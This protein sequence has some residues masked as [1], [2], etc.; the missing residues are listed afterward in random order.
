[1]SLLMDAL[2]KAEAAK[3]QSGQRQPDAPV[4]LTLVAA[5][6]SP[7]PPSDPAQI[8]ASL[9]VER[10]AI[11]A[12]E[13]ARTFQHVPQA[14]ERDAAR[15]FFAARQPLKLRS[16]PRLFLALAASAAMALVTH[17]WWQRPSAPVGLQ[18]RPGPSAAPP[19][20]PAAAHET[21][22]SGATLAVAEATAPPEKRERAKPEA[23]AE[24]EAESPIRL[25]RSR[26]QPDPT[27]ERAYEALRAERLDDAQHDYEQVL[28]DDSKNTDALLGLATLA[29]RR[30]QAESATA[31]YLQA[32]ESDPKD[33]YAQAGLI[34]LKGHHAPELSESRLKTLLASQPD[35]AALNFALGNV[36]SR[37]TRWGDAQ[38]AYFRAYAAEPDNADHLFNLAVSLDHLQQ[39]RLATHYYRLALDASG[40]GSSAFDRN[41]VNGRLREL[42]PP[43]E[44][45]E[46]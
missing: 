22:K 14:A 29:A 20:R 11:P 38:Q 4:E 28:R 39:K 12:A 34:N 15:N 6:T 21:A 7:P 18:E 43:S 33:A 10:T 27:L 17:V 8:L 46:R 44:S 2:R 35:S 3:Q 26:P 5:G 24:E 41:R 13:P 37:Q 9:D 45:S 32:L 1:M 31:R 25:S 40:T 36:H 16:R 42:Q 30:G 23:V 19:L